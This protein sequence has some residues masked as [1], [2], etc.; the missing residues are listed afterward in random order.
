MERSMSKFFNLFVLFIL[1]MFTSEFLFAQSFSTGS[2]GVLM[3]N[4]GRIRIETPAVAG[5]RQIDRVSILVASTPTTVFDYNQDGN[6]VFPS[7]NVTTPLLSN[8]EMV[9]ALDN[10][11][12]T[13]PL[14][15][16]V[17]IWTNI[18]GWNNGAYLLLKVTVKN[19]ESSPM[20][21][22]IGAEIIPKIDNVYGFETCKYL[23]S[24]K[25]IDVFKTNAHVGFKMFSADF[26]GVRLLNWVDGYD[27]DTSF[28]RWLSTPGFDPELT[29]GADG[30]V[31]IFSHPMTVINPGDSVS[32]WFGISYGTSETEMITNMNLC[33]S[34][35]MQLVPVELTAFTAYSGI[36][37]V[38]LNWSTATETN[39]YGFEIQRKNCN[40]DGS[41]FMTVAFVNG[42]GTVTNEQSY[43]YT[44][45][46][47]LSETGKF[48]YRLKQVDFNGQF[49]YSDE[50]EV[51]LNPVDYALFQNYPNPFNPSTNISFSLPK[52]TRVSLK[53]YDV[54][55]NEVLSLVNDVRN[56]GTHTVTFDANSFSNGVYFYKL[57]TPDFT[58]TSKMIL[59]K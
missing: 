26:H 42:A 24:P 16:D 57:E 15:P 53:I 31:G 52:E 10:S 18:Y 20:N 59:M 50:I 35:Y 37:G 40:V 1:L 34:K 11:Y 22:I 12:N 17:L 6:G 23:P 9:N 7:S 43:A 55:G 49:A 56:A 39:N 48:A 25:I 13:P 54:L 44:D 36:N 46:G 41:P 45:R 33:G 51:D 28:Y 5:T 38:D 14:P 29:V 4:G 19:R 27:Q 58:K 30:A 3:S 2:V 8:F 21:A 32:I 47:V